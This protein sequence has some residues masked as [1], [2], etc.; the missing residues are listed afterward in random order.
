MYRDPSGWRVRD[1]D[2]IPFHVDKDFTGLQVIWEVFYRLESLDS[3][4]HLDLLLGFSALDLASVES[5]LQ[6]SLLQLVKL[7]L[8]AL[9]IFDL[10]L[11]VLLLS[12]LR[13]EP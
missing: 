13:T 1:Q 7:H 11:L 8:I 9:T 4:H 10:V 2:G 12:S 6:I 3:V 5:Q